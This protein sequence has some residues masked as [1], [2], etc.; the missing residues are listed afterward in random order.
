[1][2]LPILCSVHLGLLGI[3]RGRKLIN[4]SREIADIFCVDRANHWHPNKSYQNGH[5]SGGFAR[6]E[7]ALSTPSTCKKTGPTQMSDPMRKD[8]PPQRN[9]DLEIY[10]FFSLINIPTQHPIKSIP[11][12]VKKREIHGNANLTASSGFAFRWGE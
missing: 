8:R 4:G 10:L 6:K 7:K 12:G 11:H 2:K 5:P 3:A 9:A 1:M